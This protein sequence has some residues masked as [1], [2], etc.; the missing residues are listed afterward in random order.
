MVGLIVVMIVCP[1]IAQYCV[2]SMSYVT[3]S[4][5]ALRGLYGVKAGLENYTKI[6]E[7]FKKATEEEKKEDITAT[8][9]PSTEENSQG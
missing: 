8:Q 5:V 9:P 3:T 6:K 4:F 7:D 2:N 1:P